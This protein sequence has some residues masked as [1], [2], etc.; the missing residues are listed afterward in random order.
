LGLITLQ[1]TV[2][3]I[4]IKKKRDRLSSMVILA[5]SI[6]SCSKGLS[7]ICSEFPSPEPGGSTSR[8]G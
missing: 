3:V 8:R 6:G 7:D 5:A 4:Y 1:E 2:N